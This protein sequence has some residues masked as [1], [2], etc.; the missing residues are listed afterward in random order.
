MGRY[1]GSGYKYGIWLSK[2]SGFVETRVDL[3]G[4]S[5]KYN[6]MCFGDET[7]IWEVNIPHN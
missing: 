2:E 1:N 3:F 6:D 4:G 7:S 5:P